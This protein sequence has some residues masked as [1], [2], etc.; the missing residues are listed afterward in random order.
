V[1]GAGEWEG[2]NFNGPIL[3]LHRTDDLVQSKEIRS[4]G[5][6]LLIEPFDD[7]DYLRRMR[8]NNVREVGDAVMRQ[9]IVAGI[10][11][12]YKS[13]SLFMTRID[14]WRPVSTLEDAEL[15]TLRELA[16]RIMTDGIVNPRAVT[17]KGP[18]APGNWAYGRAGLACR[19]CGTRIRSAPQGDDRRTTFWCPSCQA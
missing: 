12:I 11:N 19:V 14:P 2:V 6:D 10:G 15:V 17:F 3:E 18:G 13:E 8:A 7:E 1:L 16:T 9:R 4:L 5:P